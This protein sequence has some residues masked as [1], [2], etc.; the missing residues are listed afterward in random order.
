MWVYGAPCF[1]LGLCSD[2]FCAGSYCAGPSKVYVK[3]ISDVSTG[4]V[5]FPYPPA[6]L[7]TQAFFWFT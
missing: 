6:E 5:L 3:V 4:A 1:C 7:F 2:I